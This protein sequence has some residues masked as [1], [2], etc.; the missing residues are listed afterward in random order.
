MIRLKYNSIISIIPVLLIAF[1]SASNKN[2]AQEAHPNILWI[3]ADD[4]G[5]DLA[6]YG[7]PLVQT[8]HLDGLAM[9]SMTYTGLFAVASVCS[10]TRS[11]LVTGM[12]PVSINSH[13]HR[14]RT[15]DSLQN[16]IR[17]ITEYFRENGYFV[18]N[19]SSGNRKTYGK[20]DYNFAHDQKKLY[21]GSDWSQRADGQPFFAQIQIKYPHRPFASDTINPINPDEVILPPNYPNTPLARKDWA[22]YLETVQLTDHH[23]GAILKR[24]EDEGLA[25][26]TIVFFFGDQGQP[27]VRA[28]QFL[29]DAGIRTPLIVRIPASSAA[30]GGF[31]HRIVST[32]DIAAATLALAGIPIPDHIQGVDFLNEAAVPREYAF[33]MRDRCDETVDRIRSVRSTQFKYI[34]N[35]YP[36]RPYTQFNA[37]KKSNYPVLT[38]MELL[39]HQGGLDE[40]QS[41]FMADSRPA[42]ELYDIQS[43]PH[44]LHNLASLSDYQNTLQHYRTVLDQWLVEADHGVYP[45][46]DEE[47]TYA[48]EMMEDIFASE[49]QKKGLETTISDAELLEYWEG[50]LLPPVE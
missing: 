19:G 22:M 12:Y 18:S 44:E 50:T 48:R 4:L 2:E 25:D 31:D 10:P 17:P 8:P 39:Y 46:P 11:S 23:V 24:L 33:S 27:H 9:E 3:V 6:C 15:R 5:T 36:D 35:F 26:N 41:L 49:M 43:D 32:V 13:Q 7:T 14:A 29:Y 38:Q 1:S 28:K 45:E 34:R 20:T 42:E 37:Y 16:S 40:L 30:P 21:D 47:I